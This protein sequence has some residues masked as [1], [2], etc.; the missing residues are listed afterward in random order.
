MKS[1]VETGNGQEMALGTQKA[2]SRAIDSDTGEGL[3]LLQARGNW[4]GHGAAAGEF[5]TGEEGWEEV[6]PAGFAF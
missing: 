1:T 4:G 2:Q 5:V 6:F 3:P